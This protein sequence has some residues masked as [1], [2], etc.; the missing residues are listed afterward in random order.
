MWATEVNEA[1][2]RHVAEFRD[3]LK[4]PQNCQTKRRKRPEMPT[5]LRATLAIGY[6]KSAVADFGRK[7]HLA[8]I[9]EYDNITEYNTPLQKQNVERLSE[10]GDGLS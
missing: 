7:N 8:Q 10:F 5:P 2:A 1:K 6:R 4:L 3:G 9:T